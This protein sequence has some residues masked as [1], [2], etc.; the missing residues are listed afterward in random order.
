MS[1][2]F[3]VKN[4]F[5]GRGGTRFEREIAS[6]IEAVWNEVSLEDFNIDNVLIGA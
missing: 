3:L 6:V 4:I 5:S 2:N 1:S